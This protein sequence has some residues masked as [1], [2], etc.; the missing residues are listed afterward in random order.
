MKRVMIVGQPGSG[1]S[2][3]AR[4]IGDKTGLPVVH[5]DRIHHL[6]GWKERPRAEKIAMALAEQAK[7]NWVFEG[8]LSATYED[9]FNRADTFV[10]LDIPLSLR[11]WRIVM[12]TLKHYGRTRPDM[13][14]GC[15]E[16]FN[17]EFNKW[18]WDTRH[19]GRVKPLAMLA[20]AQGHK[21]AW[22][23]RNRSDVAAFV[24]G[25]DAGASSGQKATHGTPAH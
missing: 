19:T 17:A 25:L 16:R 14:D 13:Q 3:L 8:G 18:I 1:K 11:S 24:A 22:H 4:I 5:V 6:P 2:T 20:R 15:P 12:R 23:L 21:A 7:P 10:F 9:R